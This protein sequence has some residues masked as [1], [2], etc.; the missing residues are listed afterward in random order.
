M[1]TA[2][3]ILPVL[4]EDDTR[5]DWKHARYRTTVRVKAGGAEVTNKLLE[6]PEL[7]ELVD[8]GRAAWAVEVR[9]PKTLYAHTYQ[10]A[11]SMFE[12]S[13]RPSDVDGQ[14]FLRP[15]LIATCEL[16]LSAA[17]L[18]ENIWEPPILVPTGWWLAQ[19]RTFKSQ[20]LAESLL[21]FRRD[22]NLKDGTMSV[23]LDMGS[24]NLQFM[25]GL[26]PD[27]YDHRRTDRN[28]QIAGLIAAFSQLPQSFTSEE[29]DNA[30]LDA[31]KQRLEDAEVPT[32]EEDNYDPALAATTI[33]AFIVTP[34]DDDGHT[35]RQIYSVAEG[36]GLSRSKGPRS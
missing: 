23:V 20:G 11:T 17:G 21:K 6:A 36:L 35:C 1:V 14:L 9:C 3:P 34:D 15:G 26:A 32:W 10:H 31:V 18:I 33:E 22:R 28:V 19:G 27:L 13:W 4:T 8:Q 12:L 29:S 30:V 16:S 25:V 5:M 2:Q 24:G 7:E